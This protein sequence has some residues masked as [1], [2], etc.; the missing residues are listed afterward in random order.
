MR[1]NMFN[2]DAV[3]LCYK[4]NTI[5][6]INRQRVNINNNILNIQLNVRSDLCELSLQF[7]I[8]FFGRLPNLKITIQLY[9]KFHKIR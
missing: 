8:H 4:V 3:R 5:S 7:N 2:C 6:A 1:N 9:I